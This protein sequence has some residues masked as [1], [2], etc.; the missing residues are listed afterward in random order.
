MTN[1]MTLAAT[2]CAAAL[3]TAPQA[4]E[5]SLGE[6]EFMNS[7]AQCHGAAGKGDGVIAGYLNTAIPDLSMLQANNGGVF[8]VSRVYEVIEHSVDVGAHGTTD[9][10]AW[11]N[12]YKYGAEQ[13]LGE[14]HSAEA[15]DAFIRTRILALI[16]HLSSLQ[17]Q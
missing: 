16:E 5:M 8:P 3:A 11:G 2:I 12:R 15:R 1:P 14:F 13:T 17:E 6:S 9:M 7:C 10:P 4:A